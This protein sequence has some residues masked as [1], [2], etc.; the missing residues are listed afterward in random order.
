M[1]TLSADG[2]GDGSPRSNAGPAS[3]CQIDSATNGI[4]GCISFRMPSSTPTNTRCTDSRPAGSF[5]R[6]FA[7]SI[8]QSQNSDH[9]KS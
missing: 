1:T 4:T 5:R 8:Y 9:V 6:P 3:A 2:S 7:I